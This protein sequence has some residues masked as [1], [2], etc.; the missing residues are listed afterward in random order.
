MR[1]FIVL[2]TLAALAGCGSPRLREAGST[3]VAA[4]GEEERS[5]GT[6]LRFTGSQAEALLDRARLAEEEGEYEAA[7][8]DYLA[9]YR[10][11]THADALREAA[12]FRVGMV[13]GSP[14]NV[15]KDYAK[16][17]EYLERFIEEYPDSEH[18]ETA[19]ANLEKYREIL[20][21]P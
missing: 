11:P 16:A 12:L 8:R 6:S 13:Y 1:R 10:D 17:V 20:A 18:R 2:I 14:L 15:R 5:V 19:E 4:D 21:R 7:V 9:V 3:R